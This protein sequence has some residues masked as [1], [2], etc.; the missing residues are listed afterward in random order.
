MKEGFAYYR[1]DA[2]RFHDRKIK[3]LKRAH[4]CTGVCVYEYLLCEIYRD[5][6]YYIEASEDLIFDCSEYWDIEEDEVVSII[7]TCIQIG[8]FNQEMY[9][10]KKILTSVGIQR[11][12]IE[13]SA[14]LKRK[15]QIAKVYSLLN[16]IQK[17][18]GKNDENSEELPKIPEKSEETPKNSEE[19]EKIPE[20]NRQRKERKERKERKGNERNFFSMSSSEQEKKVEQFFFVKKRLC[21]CRDEAKKYIARNEASGWRD[22]QGRQIQDPVAYANGWK[23]DTPITYS[24]DEEL[25]ELWYGIYSAALADNPIAS[26]LLNIERLSVNDGCLD[27]SCRLPEEADI[28]HDVA[29]RTIRGHVLPLPSQIKEFSVC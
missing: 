24:G 9:T 20:K 28:I 26:V 4:S 25:G 8:L 6:G 3:R 29:L 7:E 19:L 21:N 15:Q 14:T 17:N 11:R 12:F 2:D 27:V 13:M 5:R 10:S 16:P 22:P 1:A 18:S 23:C